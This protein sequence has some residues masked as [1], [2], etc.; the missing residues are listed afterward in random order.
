MILSSSIHS[1]SNSVILQHR[2]KMLPRILAAGF[3]LSGL[4][5][6]QGQKDSPDAETA[7]KVPVVEGREIEARQAASSTL[8]PLI[9]ETYYYCEPTDMTASFFYT[10]YITAYVT[11][12]PTGT[13]TE[14]Y[15]VTDSCTG[16]SSNY[17]R[18][19]TAPP[20]FTVDTMT[21]TCSEPGA[22]PV[23]TIVTVTAPCG[24]TETGAAATKFTPT[25]DSNGA[26][27]TGSNGS[28]AQAGATG[29]KSGAGVTSGPTS[30]PTG[31][32]TN[33]GS[34]V[35]ASD[36]WLLTGLATSMAVVAGIIFALG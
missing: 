10:T 33:G 18:P 23:N 12:C 24:C 7:V 8:P 13:Y 15:T 6:A 26:S 21:C 28:P 11:V 17:E 20:G 5:S 22:C 2:G 35:V 16:G 32:H 1:S 9:T 19:T 4:V 30:T 29:S 36:S 25:E 34:S 27:E 3:L 31:L 14:I